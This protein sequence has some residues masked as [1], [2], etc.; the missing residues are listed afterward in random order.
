MPKKII[1][2]AGPIV[3]F[4]HEGDQWHKWAVKQFSRFS[5]FQTCDAALAEACARLAYGGFSQSE[6]VRLVEQGAIKLTFLTNYNIGR[7]LALMEKY[8]DVPMDFA[9]ACIVV[10]SEEEKDALVVTTDA[11]FSIYRRYGRDVIPT[12]RP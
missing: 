2:D 7:V 11:D 9:D 4:L 5:E 10:M 12:L 1:V 6:A 8:S 3:A